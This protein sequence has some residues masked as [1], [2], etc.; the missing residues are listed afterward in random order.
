MLLWK[1]ILVGD[2][3]GGQSTFEKWVKVH[4][5]KDPIIEGAFQIYGQIADDTNESPCDK[6]D[7]LHTVQVS[8]KFTFHECTPSQGG[9]S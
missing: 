8:S 5:R 2:F 3:A 6:T 4:F 9:V 1:V 7:V